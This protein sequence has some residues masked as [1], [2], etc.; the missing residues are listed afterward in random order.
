M[1]SL[2]WAMDTETQD[3][4][5]VLITVAGPKS[6][7][8]RLKFPHSY[9]EIHAFMWVRADRYMTYNMDYDARALIKFLP[10]AVW[11]KLYR[12]EKVRWMNFSLVYKPG[13][14]FS[15]SNDSG[16]FRLYDLAGHFGASLRAASKA[17]LGDDRKDDIPKSWYPQMAVKLAD[18]RTQQKVIKYGIRDAEVCRD[19]WY[20]L[21]RQYRKIGVPAKSLSR[22]IS[23]GSI[24]AGYFGKRVKSDVSAH[25]NWTAQ[26]AYAGGRIEV[27]KRGN[28]PH[29]WIYDL[30]SAYPAVLADLPD[31]RKADEVREAGIR[32]DSLYSVHHVELNIP[33]DFKLPPFPTWGAGKVRIYPT[34]HFLAWLTG[35]ELCY[36]MAK[37]WVQSVRDGYHLIGNP[38]PWLHDLL[39]LYK[40]REKKPEISY[41]LKIVMNSIY[42]K[43]AQ[44]ND[45]YREPYFVGSGTRKIGNKFVEKSRHLSGTTNFFVASYIT[46]HTRL[47]L[48]SA[49][50]SIGHGSVVLSATDALMTTKPLY[51]AVL[52]GKKMGDWSCVGNDTRA[53]VVGTGVYTYRDG[54]D[55]QNRMRGHRLQR[56]LIDCLKSKR[57][58]VRVKMK[59]AVTLADAVTK[60]NAD[61]NALI[62]IPR[63]LDVNF[64]RKRAWPKPWKSA[65]DL[66]RNSQDSLPLTLLL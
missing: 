10:R 33:L 7:S 58:K 4:K 23:T 25:A 15:S 3:G 62:D 14:E 31:P 36:A 38:R 49:M 64:D 29:V 24:A 60:R 45:S 43:F 28:F 19:V 30:R 61:L 63:S 26:K 47:R 21:R 22:P 37:N 11:I 42:G 53:V 48:Q 20:A 27:Y 41:A 16:S 40:M 5:A 8:G 59:V 55:W 12:D 6:E 44:R 66:L 18:S 56:P 65:A 39:K 32:P 57:S 54:K 2:E 46:A 17:M 50:D 13:R 35:P 9:G 52:T 1:E 34:G 51:P